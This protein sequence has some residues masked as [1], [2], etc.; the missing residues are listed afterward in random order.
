M[1]KQK[2]RPL[3]VVSIR[4]SPDL[5]QAMKNVASIHRRFIGGVWEDAARAYLADQTKEKQE[6]PA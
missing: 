3:E 2:K 5:A 4:I 6:V 1:K